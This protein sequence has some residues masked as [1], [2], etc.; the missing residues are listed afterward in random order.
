MGEGV[1][2]RLVMLDAAELVAFIS[3]ID[4]T[5][6]RRFYEVTLGLALI[7]ASPFALVFKSNG[8]M[9]RVTVVDQLQPA[10]HTV[11]GWAIGDIET[12][13]RALAARGVSFLRY[14]GMSQDDLG[15]WL[16]P[17]G[18]RIAWFKDPD[19]NILSLT[20]FES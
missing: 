14:E 5:R 4:P 15:I 2:N 18:A 17:S 16:A 11:L 9:L 10:P 3:T 19:G 7:E 20:Q 8:V 6:A 13:V 12:R 1:N